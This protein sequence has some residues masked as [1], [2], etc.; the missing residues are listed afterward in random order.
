MIRDRIGCGLR[1]GIVGAGPM[2]CWH[3]YTARRLGARVAAVVDPDVDRA[4]ALAK[5]GAGSGVFED[6]AAMLESVR[7]DA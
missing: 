6:A 5:D 1:V 4:R 2:G 3:A 7:L